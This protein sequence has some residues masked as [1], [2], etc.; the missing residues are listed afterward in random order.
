MKL[1]KDGKTQYVIYILAEIVHSRIL[2]L[3]SKKKG[4][5]T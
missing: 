1:E 2:A 4:R 5:K 3:D